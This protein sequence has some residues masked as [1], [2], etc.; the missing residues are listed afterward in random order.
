MWF[1]YIAQYGHNDDR[2]NLEAANEATPMVLGT[3]YRNAT[4]TV[5][6]ENNANATV[7]FY[8]GNGELNVQP[9]LTNPASS[10]NEYSTAQVIDLSDWQPVPG[11]TGIVFTGSQDGIYRYELN[12]NNNN[13]VGVR[14]TA[15]TAG[16]VRIKIDLSDNS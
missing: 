8:A 4:I 6:A 15:R 9:D 12:D 16:N 10:T 1:R 5:I 7:Q 11:D 13:W 14:M 2:Y 3:D